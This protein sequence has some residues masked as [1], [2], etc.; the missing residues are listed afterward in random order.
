MAQVKETV[1]AHF[2]KSTAQPIELIPKTYDST[3]PDHSDFESEGIDIKVV[4]VDGE[5]NVFHLDLNAVTP[6][7]NLTPT[8]TQFAD[9]AITI[10]FDPS[11]IGN[12]MLKATHEYTYCTLGSCEPSN[13]ANNANQGG[14]PQL[15][16]PP[17]IEENPQGP[18]PKNYQKCDKQKGDLS[19]IPYNIVDVGGFLKAFQG[20]LDLNAGA[21]VEDFDDPP[22]AGRGLKL[23]VGEI[24]T[25]KR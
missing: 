19:N 16:V 23:E 22:Q 11:Q 8:I 20:E 14:Q 7:I 2:A 5:G 24:N 25:G 15:P 1:V 18:P 12:E 4:R 21:R 3:N 6:A 10:D 17:P 9:G 13:S